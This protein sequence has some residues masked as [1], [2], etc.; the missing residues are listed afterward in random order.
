MLQSEDGEHG[1]G[2]TIEGRM[3]MV[4]ENRGKAGEREFLR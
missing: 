4:I 2:K 1:S 3:I